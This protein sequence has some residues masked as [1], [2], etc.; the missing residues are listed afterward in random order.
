MIHYLLHSQAVNKE[1]IRSRFLISKWIND[2]AFCAF[3]VKINVPVENP[4]GF[5][6]RCGKNLSRT[7]GTLIH[8]VMEVMQDRLYAGLLSWNR[9]SESATLPLYKIITDSLIQTAESEECCL[10]GEDAR[11][12][13]LRIF[14][15]FGSLQGDISDYRASYDEAYRTLDLL[16]CKG[17]NHFAEA[18]E[19]AHDYNGE[20]T[21]AEKEEFLSRLLA[22]DEEQG[23]SFVRQ[24]AADF[25]AQHFSMNYYIR[26]TF[27]ELEKLILEAY[28]ILHLEGVDPEAQDQA[29]VLA[30]AETI[31][32]M[33]D[34]L[35][36]HIHS[37]LSETEADQNN[38]LIIRNVILFL[39]EHA[40]ESDLNVKRV[41]D[42]VY[43][44]PTYLSNLFKKKTG[45]TIGQY[46][47]D[48]RIKAAKDF[49]R[50]PSYK[51]YQISQMVGYTDPNYF[52]KIFKKKTGKLPSEYRDSARE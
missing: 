9:K 24:K 51:L 46:I 34:Y 32:E 2:D 33:S 38:N 42:S 41:S 50:D 21:E 40:L 26:N 19:S 14:V 16:A 1:E 6:G 31:Q 27:F 5:A 22:K 18:S 11:N 39:K 49:L 8:I 7:D 37:I 20:L 28:R 13:K 52:S 25:S 10:D 29:E 3:L 4:G 47:L 44:T 17:W 48:L 12:S 36:E 23:V 35:R 15:S 43:L 45:Y 30:D